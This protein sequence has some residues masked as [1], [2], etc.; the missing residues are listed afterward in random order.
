MWPRIILILA[1]GIIAASGLIISKAANA[2]ELIAKIT[3]FQGFIGVGL[4]GFGVFD[5]LTNISYFKDILGFH[6]PLISVALLGWFF[7][8]IILGFILGMPQIAAWIPGE[9]NVET[10]VVNIQKKLLPFQTIFGI[11]GLVTGVLLLLIQFGVL[12]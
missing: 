3:P 9:G 10:K 8:S 5:L 11:V 6:A 7:G 4:L 1:G 2:K 12:K